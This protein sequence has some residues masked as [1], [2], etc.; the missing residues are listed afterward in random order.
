MSASQDFISQ[1]QKEREG[2]GKERGREGE[3]ILHFPA[4][5]NHSLPKLLEAPV[6]NRGDSLNLSVL[7]FC[8]I[9]IHHGR[10]ITVGL[11]NCYRPDTLILT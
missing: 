6:K 3:N 1:K 9:G 4:Y 2:K 11:H 10:R 7:K 8:I 5:V